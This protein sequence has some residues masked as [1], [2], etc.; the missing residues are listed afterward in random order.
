MNPDIV[1]KVLAC[2][3]LPS[4]PAVAVKVLEL[5]GR[6]NVSF[7]EIAETITA[8]AG[9]AS[10]VL[11]TVNSSFYALRKPCSSINQA[12]VMLGLSAVKTLALGFSLVSSIAKTDSKGFDYAAYWRRSLYTGVS[13]KCVAAAAKI[14][15]DEEAFLG[16]LLQDVGMVALSQ[17]LG[18]EYLAVLTEAGPDH[19]SLS[20]IE[21]NAYEM[22]HAD[23]GAQLAG[24]WKLP[25]DLMM[26]IKFHHK[27]NAAP[28]DYAQ[29]CSAVALGNIITDV[30]TTTEPAVALKKYYTKAQEWFALPE[31]QADEILKKASEGARDM[32]R[33]LSVDAG[34]GADVEAIK[35]QAKASL[36]GLKTPIGDAP[37]FGGDAV[38]PSTGLPGR[39]AFN[40]NLIVSF[41]QTAAGGPPVSIALFA[42]D[43]LKEL[44]ASD[45]EHMAETAMATTAG[46]I[47]AHFESAGA[48]LC[49][50]DVDQFA[51]I[52]PKIDRLS[53]TRLA[54]D[55]RKIMAAAPVKV[56]PPGLKAVELSLT[57]SAGAA[58][59]EQATQDKFPDAEALVTL[60]QRALVSAQSAGR[61]TMKVYVPRAQAA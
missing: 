46:M 47:R 27:P 42:L 10:K 16:G 43:G 15:R 29:L 21:F 19:N 18:D 50:F 4:L 57:L 51:A 3:K 8:D 35:T 32:A 61:N 12:I 11:R 2:Q 55:A 38:D 58:C 23:M 59:F 6:E 31:A 25:P 52:M 48:V 1:E 9:L 37:N 45:G 36:L 22:T 5:S 26:P 54:E 14:G 24:R 34:D 49:R 60:V 20:R 28:K 56:Q 13:A 30:L 44:K 40:R 53:A 39:E 33:L 17:A 7:K 41:E